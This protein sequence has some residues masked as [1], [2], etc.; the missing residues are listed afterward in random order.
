VLSDQKQRCGFRRVSLVD[1]RK[2]RCVKKINGFMVMLTILVS[3]HAFACGGGEYPVMSTHKEDGTKIGLFLSQIQME[4]TQAWSP[5]NG[6]PP[7]S[8]FLHKRLM[9]MEGLYFVNA[10]AIVVITPLVGKW[11]RPLCPLGA[12]G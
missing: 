10:G 1:I 9:S 12:S 5:E 3:S 6:E 11:S 7:L 4:Q 2:E 8:I